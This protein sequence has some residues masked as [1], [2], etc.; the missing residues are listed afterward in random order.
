MSS[1]RPVRVLLDEKGYPKL[2]GFN[3]ACYFDEFEIGP[4]EDAIS[5]Y[6]A[7]EVLER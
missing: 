2:H 3:N 6:L 4:K 7:P 5:I 1:L